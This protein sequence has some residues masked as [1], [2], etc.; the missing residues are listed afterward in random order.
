MYP[1][2]LVTSKHCIVGNW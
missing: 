1:P 2:I